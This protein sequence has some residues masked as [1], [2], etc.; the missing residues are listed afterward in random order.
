MDY[1]VSEYKKSFDRVSDSTMK[2]TI[3]KLIPIKFGWDIKEEYPHYFK[4]LLNILLSFNYKFKSSLEQTAHRR[5]YRN[6]GNF[7]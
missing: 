2:L 6:P 3:K 1:N 7:D 4:R 5:R